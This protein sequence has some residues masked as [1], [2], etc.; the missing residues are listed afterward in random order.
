M[1]RRSRGST[2]V[3]KFTSAMHHGWRRSMWPCSTRPGSFTGNSR[4]CIC[5]DN[6]TARQEAAPQVLRKARERAQNGD[7]EDRRLIDDA[8]RFLAECKPAPEGSADL[9]REL[10][11]SSPGQVFVR[12]NLLSILSSLGRPGVDAFID[13]CRDKGA[14]DMDVAHFMLR[15]NAETI[16][17]LIEASRSEDPVRRRLAA[18]L[19]T[20]ATTGSNGAEH[21]KLLVARVC[22]LLKDDDAEV[23]AYALDIVRDL[24]DEPEARAAIPDIAQEMGS[25]ERRW[26]AAQTL[27]RFGDSAL[28][29]IRQAA[30]SDDPGTRAAACRRSAR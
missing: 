1:R 11:P 21:P 29:P 22:E 30:H 9:V 24:V 4:C 28:A 14:A 13:L 17:G 10:W 23:R 12:W 19:M 20:R 18:L 5:K 7:E 27:A 3:C 26:A 8:L 6:P 25:P 2:I 16:Q 15:A